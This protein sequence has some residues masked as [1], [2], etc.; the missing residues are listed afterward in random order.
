MQPRSNE[1][2]R[3][4]RALSPG[5][6]RALTRAQQLVDSRPAGPYE[7]AWCAEAMHVGDSRALAMVEL[8]RRPD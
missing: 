3:A 4:R 8:V 7:V 5:V 1:D 2:G 6:A